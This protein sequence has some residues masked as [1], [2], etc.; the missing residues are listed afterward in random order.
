MAPG[1]VK[2]FTTTWTV[3]EE[4]VLA[5]EILNSAAAVGDP[6]EDP[7]NPDE[8]KI[9]QDEDETTDEPVDVNVELDVTKTSDKDGQKVAAGEMI[10]Y[11]I[12]VENKSNVTV[13]NVHVD[14]DK[15]GLHEVIASMAP[16]EVKSFTTT[17]IVREE[18]A[19]TGFVFN[20][21]SAEGDEIIDPK[22][23]DE[24]LIPYDEDNT[25]DETV[26]YPHTVTV[27][28]YELMVGGEQIAPPVTGT[29]NTD[30]EFCIVSPVIPGYSVDVEVV[31]GIMGEEDLVFNVIYTPVIYQLTINY[32][33]VTGAV[34]APQY[35]QQLPA[36]EEYSRLSP[37][38]GDLFCTI[39][40]VEGVMP[41][42]DVVVTVI[43]L[44]ASGTVD[45]EEPDVPAAAG[46][47]PIG[48]NAG[49]CFE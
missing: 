24:P 18:E 45:V 19:M 34:V 37:V 48:M 3:T 10:T 4:E 15:T 26:A 11:T 9:P 25:L 27:N 16:G 20:R 5:G 6:V 42:C 35:Q 29:Y 38:V 39:P 36:G 47:G 44:P 8:P 46:M 22:N 14:D 40:V 41:G 2:S 43:Y 23:P 1:E 21:A 28:Y 13:Y 7:K 30:E 31:F 32:V 49:D 12:K 33:D 17:W